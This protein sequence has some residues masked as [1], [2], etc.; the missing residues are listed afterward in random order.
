MSSVSATQAVKGC[1]VE[2]HIVFP[3]LFAAGMS[4][5]D[6]TDG[7][8]MH[9]ACDWAFIKPMGKLYYNMTI[10]LVSVIIALLVGGIEALGLLSDKLGLS[11]EFWDAIGTLD[12]NLN[13]LGFAIVGIFL[14]AWMLSYAVYRL[15]GLDALDVPCAE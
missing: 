15:K 9:G 2:A 14:A 12:D 4:L 10:T 6:T 13:Y 7:V 11:G 5:V 8:M 1:S 3:I